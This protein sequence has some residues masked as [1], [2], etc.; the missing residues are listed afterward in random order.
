MSVE[1]D[2][3][4]TPEQ[5]ENWR[6]VLLSYL[7]PYALIMPEKDVNKMKD[8]FQENINRLPCVAKEEKEC[9]FS[10]GDPIVVK[11][12]ITGDTKGKGI[13]MAIHRYDSVEIKWSFGGRA[14]FSSDE[15]EK[16]K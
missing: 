13:V 7:G 6:R 9:P 4:L 1:N 15:L 12:K 10:V 2:K 3:Q 16:K 11:N 8:R 14:R 5:V